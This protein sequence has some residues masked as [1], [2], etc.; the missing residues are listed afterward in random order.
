MR[1]CKYCG[2]R[3]ADDTS[4]CPECGKFID[5][6]SVA[7]SVLEPQKKLALDKTNANRKKR[8]VILIFVFC[9]IALIFILIVINSGKCEVDGCNNKAISGMDYCYYHKCAVTSCNN[10]KY[11]FSNYCYS[12]Y[13][14]Y[15]DDDAES[16]YKTPVYSSELKISNV[17]LSSSKNYTVVEGTLTNN[18]EQ[19]VSYVKIK[20]AF[21]DSSGKVLDT[22]WTYAVG[23]EGLEPGETCT[24]RMSVKKDS[25]IKDCSVT[26]LDFD[27]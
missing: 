9:V 1:F 4:Q 3:V 21:E 2:A 16:S 26:I 11:A 22:D 8:S 19:T 12:H 14:L 25:S 10:R 13:L 17:E 27:Y 7:E 6:K 18:S 24:W 20:G 5:T 15:D 23:S